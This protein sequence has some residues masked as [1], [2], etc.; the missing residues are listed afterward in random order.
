MTETVNTTNRKRASTKVSQMSMSA[1]R[2]LRVLADLFGARLSGEKLQCI[3]LIT[4]REKPHG[5][6]LVR[7]YD[8]FVTLLHFA[9]AKDTFVRAQSMLLNDF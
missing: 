4:Y 8:P 3:R 5:V 2:C 7:L 6:D 1:S 9:C